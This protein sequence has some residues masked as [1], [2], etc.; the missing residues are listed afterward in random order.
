MAGSQNRYREYH[1]NTVQSFQLNKVA[2]CSRSYDQD[3]QGRA[4]LRYAEKPNEIRCAS[5]RR[6]LERELAR[7]EA[8][9][10]NLRHSANLLREALAAGE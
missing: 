3:H 9:A 8:Q 4:A 1:A 7:I 2:V 6:K 5:L 10:E